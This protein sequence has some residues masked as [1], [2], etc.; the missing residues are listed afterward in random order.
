MI[1]LLPF[2][3]FISHYLVFS[4]CLERQNIII[5][6]HDPIRIIH[7]NNSPISIPKVK[8]E[9]Y[10]CVLVSQFAF[11]TLMMYPQRKHSRRGCCILMMATT[12]CTA[13]LPSL[14]SQELS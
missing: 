7:A 10:K 6:F 9:A 14:H 5:H 4:A 12:V 13:L 11:I 8:N 3:F 1:L 2:H